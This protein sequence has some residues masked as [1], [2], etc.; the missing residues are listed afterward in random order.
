MRQNISTGSHFEKSYGYSRAVRV[1]DTVYIAGTVG[2]DLATGTIPSDPAEQFR[3]AI[4]N[5]T[6]GLTEAGATLA[7]VV[8]LT[9]YVSAPA[10]FTD[11]VGPLLGETFGGIRPTNTALVVSFPW[12]GIDLEIQSIAVIG[13]GAG[14]GTAGQGG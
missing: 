8:Q 7:D 6:L 1:G 4:H 13:A 14:L 9:T 2:L 10:I 3:H 5:I 11:I 12:P